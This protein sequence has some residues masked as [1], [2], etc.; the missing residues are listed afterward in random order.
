L[1]NS[2]RTVDSETSSRDIA[3]ETLTFPETRKSAIISFSRISALFIPVPLFFCYNYATTDDGICQADFEN[4]FIFDQN[5]PKF[6][7]K[8]KDSV[9]F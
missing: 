3:S 1:Q 4:F 6:F 2:R 5:R 7:Q 9:I 8:M